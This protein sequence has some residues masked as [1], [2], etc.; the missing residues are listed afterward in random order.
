[1]I[2]LSSWHPTT[3]HSRPGESGAPS[4]GPLVELRGVGLE[5]AAPVRTRILHPLD[6]E[7]DQGAVIALVG[8]SGAGKTTLASLI[9]ALQEPS[10]GVYRFDGADVTGMS[11]RESARFRAIEVGFVFQ[12]AHLIEERSAIANVELGLTAPTVSRAASTALGLE[13]LAWV[14]LADLAERRSAYLSGGE[15]H[16]V[17]IARALVKSPRLII[18]DEPT[19]AL[20]QE[21]GRIVLDLLARATDRGATVVLVTHDL[22]AAERADRV[23]EILDGRLRSGADA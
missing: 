3:P 1:V 17:A 13:A 16:R 19:A 4:A 7:I 5:V 6:L 20:D 15:R 11:R 23:W 12:H 8:P 2:R 18:A 22:R 14:G 21:N 10:E 9:G